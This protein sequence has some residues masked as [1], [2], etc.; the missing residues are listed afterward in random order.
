M[1]KITLKHLKRL[2]GHVTHFNKL[3]PFPPYDSDW[4]E[5]IKNRIKFM[6]DSKED[7]DELPVVACKY[8]KSL[9]IISDE[10]DNDIC[11]RCGSINELETFENIYEY[12][13]QLKVK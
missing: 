5:D 7:Y 11:F 9:H 10:V 1:N 12:Q 3:G 8:C 13:K 6:K 2:L 4:V